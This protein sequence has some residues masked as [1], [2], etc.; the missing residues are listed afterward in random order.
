MSWEAERTWLAFC[1]VR[2]GFGFGEMAGDAR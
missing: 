1:V 2:V